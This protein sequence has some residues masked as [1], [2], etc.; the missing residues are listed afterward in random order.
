VICLRDGVEYHGQRKPLIA[1]F[2]ADEQWRRVKFLIK[3][4]IKLFIH[5]TNEYTF[6]PGLIQT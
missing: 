4:L 2:F 5:E 6:V 3:S 1:P